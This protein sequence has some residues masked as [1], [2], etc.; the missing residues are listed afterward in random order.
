M[1][2]MDG[3]KFLQSTR[4]SPAAAPL[5]LISGQYKAQLAMYALRLG[6]ADYLSKPFLPADVLALAEKH[7]LAG[8]SRREAINAA[9]RN[10]W[11]ITGRDRTATFEGLLEIFG[12]LGLMRVET[13]QHAVRVSRVSLLIGER[14]GLGRR[15]LDTLRIGATLHD[16]GKIVIPY[17]IVMK[18]GPLDE[19]E[20]RIMKQHAQLG[21]ELLEPFEELAA[22]GKIVLTHHERFEGGGYPQGLAGAAI[23][24][25]SRI[26]SVADTL[27]A[28]LSDRPYRR[29]R[30]L[31]DARGIVNANAGT[32]FDPDVVAAFERISDQELTQIRD[33][34]P[35]IP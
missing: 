1:P 11:E 21:W 5:V 23:P 7:C 31:S 22:A 33:E 35:D 27:D 17:N 19:R 18:P 20:W 30:S 8:Q 32:Q 2:G 26:F 3:L 29:G 24:L 28:V 6:A 16:I 10:Y 14:V 9:L 34:A 4:Q 15:M 25:G 12:G 13:W